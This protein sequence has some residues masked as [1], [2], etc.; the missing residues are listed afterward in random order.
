MI[1]QKGGRGRRSGKGKKTR[2][3][4]LFTPSRHHPITASA[5]LV[6]C[7]MALKATIC[8]ASANPTW[9]QLLAEHALRWH[10]ILRDDERMMVRLIASAERARRFL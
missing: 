8:K 4:S 9:T 5:A 2:K 3:S 1:R 7:A 10:A 6:E